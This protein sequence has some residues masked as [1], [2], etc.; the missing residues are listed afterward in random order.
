MSDIYSLGVTLFEMVT[1][2]CPY[3]KITSLF[4]L[5]LQIVNEPLPEAKLYYPDVSNR[6]QYAISKAT[7]KLPENRF[8]TCDEF[9]IYLL[10]AD[11]IALTG[12][13][14]SP[15]KKLPGS[16]RNVKVYLFSGIA[17]LLVVASLAFYL[18]R[19]SV[20][21]MSASGTS[22]QELPADS[23]RNVVQVTAKP[24]DSI[25]SAAI[26]DQNLAMLNMYIAAKEKELKT[27]L[28]AKLKAKLNNQVGKINHLLTPAELSSQFDPY[29][30]APATV[31]MPSDDQLIDDFYDRIPSMPCKIPYENRN[32]VSGIYFN[33]PAFNAAIPPDQLI[34]IVHFDITEA[35]ETD[36]N[37]CT[38]KLTYSKTGNN[39]TCNQ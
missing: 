4:E 13:P 29:F 10:E 1:G 34:I 37:P 33:K 9:K 21:K 14:V 26:P 20:I 32:Q 12:P 17:L 3:H 28:S 27:K 39:Y 7:Q 38:L 31:R 25:H 8:Q 6:L 15:G 16:K 23:T 5:Q 18:V 19:N 24:V 30:V 35:G 22:L 2:K 36:K 11:E